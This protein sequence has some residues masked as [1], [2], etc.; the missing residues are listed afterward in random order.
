MIRVLHIVT[1]MNRAGLENRLM[2]IYENIN[3]DSIQFDF[4]TCR[5]DSGLYDERII[6]LGGRV[7]YNEPLSLNR[8]IRIPSRFR[9][10]LKE[11][12][13]YKIVH[14]HLNQWC[15]VVL[16]GAMQAGVPIRIA[17]SRTALENLSLKNLV[18]NIIKAPVNRYATHRLA[19]SRKAAKWL[20]GERILQRNLVKIF[21]NAIDVEK[22]R[23]SQETRM[24]SRKDLGLSDEL[25]LIHVGN[26]RPEKNHAFLI[27]IFQALHK[28]VPKTKLLLVGNDGMQGSI[29]WY[30]K[31]LGVAGH[32]LFLGSRC[33]VPELLCAGDVFVFPSLYEGFPGALL[34]AQASGLP[35]LVSEKITKEV[36]LLP[37]TYF[38]SLG[39]KEEWVNEIVNLKPN[40]E[41]EKAVCL[42]GDAGYNIKQL[43][44]IMEDFYTHI[45]ADVS[46][47]H[48]GKAI[49][50][51]SEQL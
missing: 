2:D 44:E 38:I 5:Q 49:L 21:P 15:G 10:F 13:E 40:P 48:G 46:N 14:C 43:T 35:C 45:Y 7:F 6:E 19:V 3:R 4:Y 16:L 18:K 29:Q 23:F 11:H 51:E 12:S 41:R 17:H 37:S 50:E 30:A 39:S 31:E 34:E 28:K 22:Y 8:I 25:T 20:F 33:D 27:E 26:L 36:L 47:F 9:R 32:V 24:M 42:I 1:Q